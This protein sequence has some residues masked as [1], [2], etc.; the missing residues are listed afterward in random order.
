M[1]SSSVPTWLVQ[2]RR[3][4][5]PS[6]PVSPSPGERFGVDVSCRYNR[7]MPKTDLIDSD[8]I[9]AQRSFFGALV[10]FSSPRS[11]QREPGTSTLQRAR[12][13]RALFVARFHVPAHPIT[14]PATG[15]LSDGR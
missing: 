9:N 8:G 7:I 12:L 14:H 11:R 2:P 3:R 13:R 4:R 10:R 6:S 15:T 1:A 5:S